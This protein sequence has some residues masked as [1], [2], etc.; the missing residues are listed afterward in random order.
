[1]ELDRVRIADVD[2][3]T[4]QDKFSSVPVVLLT[5]NNETEAWRQ[6]AAYLKSLRLDEVNERRATAFE[7]FKAGGESFRERLR[8]TLGE[9]PHICRSTRAALAAMESGALPHE[10]LADDDVL[11]SFPDVF[12]GFPNSKF[13]GGAQSQEAAGCGASSSSP[14]DGHAKEVT[15]YDRTC[16]ASLSV[17]YSGT[18]RW[19]LWPAFPVRLSDGT[20]LPAHTRFET[21]LQPGEILFFPPAY[22]HATHILPSSA[23]SIAVVQYVLAPVWARLTALDREAVRAHP[24]GYMGCL[25][26]THRLPRR[27]SWQEVSAAVLEYAPPPSLEE[28]ESSQGHVEL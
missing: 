14:S 27:F 17:Q 18:K 19:S 2:L 11:A 26:A 25:R 9:I 7:G 15:H 22:F 13:C 24:L 3:V 21:T 23:Y 16:S 6:R 28:Q 4:F 12:H 8:M 1:M 5:S 20:S 10:E